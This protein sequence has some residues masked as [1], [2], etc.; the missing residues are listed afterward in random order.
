MYKLNDFKYKKG[1]KKSYTRADVWDDVNGF[2]L[3]K[4]E[5]IKNILKN[6]NGE[7]TK[8]EYN[9]LNSIYKNKNRLIVEK[10]NSG[11]NSYFKIF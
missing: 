5:N 11:Y 4:R 1:Y 7:I 2:K 3:V 6:V 8:I 10:Y 9:L